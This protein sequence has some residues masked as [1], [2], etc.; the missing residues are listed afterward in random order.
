MRSIYI[1][2]FV[3]GGL[4]TEAQTSLYNKLNSFLSTQTK[5]K[6]SQRLIAINVWSVNDKSSRD[7]NKEFDGVYTIYQNA[8]LKGGN[9][10]II[11]MNINFD[12][13]AVSSDIALNKDG[14]SKI[15][16]V[17]FDNSEIIKELNGKLPGYNIVFDENGNL[18]YENLKCGSVLNEVQKLIT[19]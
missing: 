11:V 3:L 2:F 8:K 16:K 6:V 12:G 1:V 18:V 14:I 15:I 5:Q 17:P 4:F 13:D 9:K 19:R 10:G 7:L